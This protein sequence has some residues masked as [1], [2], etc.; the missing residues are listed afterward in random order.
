MLGQ[1]ERE[2]ETVKAIKGF[3][4]TLSRKEIRDTSE[5][6]LGKNRRGTNCFTDRRPSWRKAMFGRGKRARTSRDGV[7]ARVGTVCARKSSARYWRACGAR[8]V[9]LRA[10]KKQAKHCRA[11]WE[12]NPEGLSLQS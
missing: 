2:K 4:W 10:M 5:R 1:M 3:T 6:G 7:A 12:Q 8:G 9:E 11:G